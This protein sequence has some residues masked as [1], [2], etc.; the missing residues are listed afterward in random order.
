MSS[1]TPGCGQPEP[2]DGLRAFGAVLKNFRKRAAY[3]QDSLSR[4]IGYS[5]HFIASVEQGRR[6]PPARFIDVCEV[7]LD[8]FG[9]LRLAVNQ[10]SRQRGLA[11]WFQQW[12]Q[13]EREALSLY[14]YECRLIPGLL[15]TQAYARALFADQLPPLNDEQIETQL[16]ARIERQRLLTEQP[17]TAYSF[18]LEEHLFLRRVGGVEVTQELIQHVLDLAERRNIELQI[19][20]L[21][22]GS[23]A[24]LAGPVQLLETPENRW[25]AYNEGQRNG[26]F[27]SDPQEISVLQR[28]YARMR[29]QALHL[30]DSASLLQRMRGA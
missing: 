1:S 13:L 30:G 12:A 18:I 14:T 24:G 26:Q 9:T 29:S 17:N 19:M 2:A 5:A 20:P 6:F 28:R 4:E 21:A 7:A 27:I 22:S 10:L 15:Q 16:A 8:A 23:H 11:S 25:F 3:T